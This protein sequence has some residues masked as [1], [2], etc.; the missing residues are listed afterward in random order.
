MRIAHLKTAVLALALGTVFLF[1]QKK[2]FWSEKPYTEWTEKEVDKLLRDSPWAKTIP[3][4]QGPMLSSQ[5]GRGGEGE[6][7]GGAGAESYRPQPKLVITWYSRPVR[8]AAA[9]RLQLA[10]VSGAEKQIEQLLKRGDSA[11]YELLVVG[12]SPGRNPEALQALKEGTYLQKK[13]K[14][15]LF[16]KNVLTPKE[17]GDPLVLFFDAR[18][19]DGSPMLKPED[20]EVLLVFKMGDNT[21]RTTFKLAD[22]IVNGRLE[23]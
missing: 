15:K 20:K 3:L 7:V 2:G 17:R 16:L 23:L 1:A 5:R 18:A 6:D 8:E 11:F 12:W 9:R 14:E 21:V 4:S 13:N 22:M 19:A 10:E